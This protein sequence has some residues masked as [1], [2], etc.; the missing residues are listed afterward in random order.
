MTM[1]LSH[2]LHNTHR[3]WK[4]FFH[5][6]WHLGVHGSHNKVRKEK[7]KWYSGGQN[8][9]KSRMLLETIAVLPET[10]WKCPLHVEH[11]DW[12]FVSFLCVVD[13]HIGV[14][15]S[16]TSKISLFWFILLHGVG[17]TVFFHVFIRVGWSDPGPFIDAFFSTCAT[18]CA[19]TNTLAS[20]VIYQVNTSKQCNLNHLICI[21]W[22]ICRF[23][24]Y[25]LCFYQKVSRIFYCGHWI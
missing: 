15:L 17:S 1:K 7:R 5:F 11:F 19:S 21:A 18:T 4:V 23:Y 6:L 12:L 16:F 22:W 9:R 14:F 8:E 13:E 25:Y 2:C 3:R 10:K 20:D 24:Y